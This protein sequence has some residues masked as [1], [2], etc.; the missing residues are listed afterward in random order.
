MATIK[1]LWQIRIA[2]KVRRIRTW[3]VNRLNTPLEV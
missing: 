3:I 2:Q 1:P